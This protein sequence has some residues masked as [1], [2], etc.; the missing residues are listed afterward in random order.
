VVSVVLLKMSD[1]PVGLA[2]AGIEEP[3]PDFPDPEAAAGVEYPL[4]GKYVQAKYYRPSASTREITHLVCHITDSGGSAEAIAQ[5]FAAPERKV[6]AHYV[7]GR[8]G[9]IIQMVKHNDV[10]FHAS[11]AN[12]YSIGIE[13]VAKK[14][15]PPTHVQYAAS[16]ALVRWLCQRYGIPLSRSRVV[17]HAEIDTLTTHKHCPA[18]AWDWGQYWKVVTNGA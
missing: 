3:L 2:D 5:W 9:E 10:A 11:N 18:I 4:S 15:L 17:G 14:G 8:K 6:S 16:A 12:G 13:H 1:V 7:I